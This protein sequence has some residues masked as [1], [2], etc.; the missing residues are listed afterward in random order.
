MSY[1]KQLLKYSKLGK[2]LDN[3]LWRFF[4]KK[5]RG[6]GTHKLLCGALL[7]PWGHGFRTH[8]T[9]VLHPRI[10]SN[11]GRWRP[12][13][14]QEQLWVPSWVSLTFPQTPTETGTAVFSLQ[15]LEREAPCYPRTP[16]SR[17]AWPAERWWNPPFCFLSLH[18]STAVHLVLDLS[19]QG[20]S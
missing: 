13:R 8:S 20:L 2:S 9:T 12:Y 1:I 3:H 15:N 6:R 18:L 14:Q 5:G 10:P 7:P 17:L 11:G 4:R 19:H 16:A